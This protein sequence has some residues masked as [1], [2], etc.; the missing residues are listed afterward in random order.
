MRLV[1]AGCILLVS[2]VAAPAEEACKADFLPVL[3]M[4]VD[5]SGDVALKGATRTT[6]SAM[7]CAKWANG[8]S[9]RGKGKLEFVGEF[10]PIGGTKFALEGQVSDYVGPGT[11]GPERLSGWGSPFMVLTGD[12]RWENW[13]RDTPLKAEMQISADGSGSLIFEGFITDHAAP[14]PYKS[15]SGTVT[16]TCI[17]PA[18]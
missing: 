5:V 16:W 18:G 1:S 13:E 2:A 15:I 7:S 3:C 17:D 9:P 4:N 8:N 11:Y 6:A 14:P 10:A 12:T